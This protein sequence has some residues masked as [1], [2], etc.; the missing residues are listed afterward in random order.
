MME[1]DTSRP[2][3]VAP[4]SADPVL[5]DDD[6]DLVPRLVGADDRIGL[7]PLVG[8]GSLDIVG[9]P[10]HQGDH[11]GVLLQASAVLQVGDWRPLV[12]PLLGLAVHLR[13]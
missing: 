2:Q 1:H 3:L 13:E 11:I 7:A 10:V 12:L 4:G 5:A 8:R 6:L 9:V